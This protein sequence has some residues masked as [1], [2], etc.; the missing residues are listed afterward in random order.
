MKMMDAAGVEAKMG[1]RPDQIVDLLGLWGDTSDNI[2]GAPGVG[3]KGA[4]QII[5]QY[6]TIENAIAHA[7]EI[8]RKT[9]RESLKNNVGDDPPV[10]RACDDS[11][12]YADHA[13]TRHVDL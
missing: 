3:E 10:A 9:Y 7:D 5:Q 13:G 1:V 11:L 12:R 6:G 4:K 2:P 8:S